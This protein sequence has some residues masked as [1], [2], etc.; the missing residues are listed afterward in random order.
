MRDFLY[1]S[2]RFK[3][4]DIPRI[5]KI[6]EANDLLGIADFNK[7]GILAGLCSVR[8]PI[9][10]KRLDIFR[11]L[12]STD[13]EKSFIRLDREYTNSELDKCEYLA[14]NIATSGLEN[15][16]DSQT[17]DYKNACKECGAGL[18]P[19]E[20]LIISKNSMR[21]K[22]LDNTAHYQWLVFNK[23]LADRIKLKGYS[24]IIFQS[25]KIG[26]NETDYYW[27]KISNILPEFHSSSKFRKNHS[28]CLTCNKCGNF[29][30]LETETKFVYDKEAYK[31][32]K[33]FNLTYEYFGEWKYSKKGGAQLL[34]ISQNIRQFMINEKVRF[35]KY[36][37]IEIL[38]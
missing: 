35:L 17:Y 20:P 15:P 37:P 10:D 32:F 22:L 24:G 13:K 25:I 28:I 18:I 33:D 29:V 7:V 2:H 9:N 23:V 11:E 30:N 16:V 3:N 27:G 8:L 31:C 1:I 26:R 4:E 38:K 34:I 19:H 21:E 36:Q 14:V 12:T 5:E 6:L